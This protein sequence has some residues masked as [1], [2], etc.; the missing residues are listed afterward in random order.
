ML[1][2]LSIALAGELFAFKPSGIT[3]IWLPSGI[4]LVMLLKWGLRAAPYIY[5]ADFVGNFPGVLE[6][7]P[8]E[9]AIYHTLFTSMADLIAPVIAMFLFHHYLKNGLQEGKDTLI[10]FVC[11]CLIP[12]T[13]SSTLISINLIKS[14]LIEEEQFYNMVLMLFF[15]DSLGVFWVFHI[16]SGWEQQRTSSLNRSFIVSTSIIV[17]LLILGFNYLP[18]MIFLI[19]PVLIYTAFWDEPFNVSILSCLTMIIIIIATASGVGPLGVINSI[20][21]NTELITFIFAIVV[22]LFSVSLQNAKLKKSVIKQVKLQKEKEF[23]QAYVATKLQDKLIVKDNDLKQ[24]KEGKRH[25]SHDLNGK[26]AEF[27][28]VSHDKFKLPDFEKLSKEND[29]VINAR[30]CTLGNLKDP[31]FDV[32]ALAQCLYMSRSTLQRKIESQTQ[33]TAAQFIRY[34]RLEVAHHYI[35]KNTH[36]TLAETAYAVGFKHP[37]YFSKLYR[38]YIELLNQQ[39]S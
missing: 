35:E 31:N 10:F 14:G 22:T 34:I 4:G 33:L 7:L 23:V 18:W 8:L 27:Q 36:R 20:E 1:Y 11:T 21:K 38:K 19:A 3:I 6:V 13:I 17:I 32:K 26:N 15:A 28:A 37:G 25:V 24:V 16:Y 9:L 5:I 12:L 39:K 30:N 2:C 29:F